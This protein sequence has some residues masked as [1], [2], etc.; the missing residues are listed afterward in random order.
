[1]FSIYITFPMSI[2]QLTLTML[3]F[4]YLK[5]LTETKRVFL[6]VAIIL[7]VVIQLNTHWNAVWVPRTNYNIVYWSAGPYIQR[8]YC[9]KLKSRAIILPLNEHIKIFLK[10]GC[11]LVAIITILRCGRPLAHF[12]NCNKLPYFL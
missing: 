10:S 9:I 8:Y 1:M 3:R 4:I 12:K 11:A 2:F 5:W 7:C 6:L